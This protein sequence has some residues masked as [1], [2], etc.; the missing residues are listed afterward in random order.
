MGPLKLFIRKSVAV[1]IPDRNSSTFLIS[2]LSGNET[3]LLHK[4]FRSKYRQRLIELPP[5]SAKIVLVSPA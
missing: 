5:R 2:F 3:T 1:V 4:T